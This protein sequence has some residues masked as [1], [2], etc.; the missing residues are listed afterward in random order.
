[1]KSEAPLLERGEV[2]FTIESRIIRELGERLVKQ[3]EIALLELVKNS[4]DA[5]AS[6]CNISYHPPS[7]IAVEDNGHGMTVEDFKSNWMRIGT[8]SKGQAEHSAK[9]GRVITGE[10]GIGRFAV[11]FLGKQLLLTSVAFDDQHGY[12]TRLDAEFDWPE[13]D[14]SEDLGTVKVP[15]TLTR[16]ANGQTGTTLTIKNLQPDAENINFRAVR[17]SAMSVVSPYQTLL[18]PASVTD[19]KR[20]SQN[21]EDVGFSL[22]ISDGKGVDESDVAA[23]VLEHFVLRAVLR[24]DANRLHLQVFRRD[25]EEPRI[26]IAE[27]LENL[28]GPLYADIRFFP[29]RGGTFTGLPVD[30][31]LAK[32]WIKEHSGVKIFDRTFRVYPYGDPGDDWLQLSA[33]TARNYRD[34]RSSV[35]LKHFP[36]DDPTKRSTE[37]NYMLRLPYPE[38]LVGVVQV[39][40]RRDIEQKSGRAG[41]IA[42]A[43]REGF[44]NN[45]AFRQLFDLVRGASEAIAFCDRELQIE[46]EEQEERERLKE[47]RRE[48]RDAVKQIQ[49]NPH[50]ARSVKSSLVRTLTT[51]QRTVEEVTE[52]N[53]ERAATLEVM[54][55]LGV[56]A[57]FMTHEFGVALDNL[58]RAHRTI[59]T[60]AR[61]HPDL[62]KDADAIS[63]RIS[64]LKDFVNYSQAYI[65]GAAQKPTRPYTVKP[66][67][68]QVVRIF[69]RYASARDIEISVDIDSSLL[70]PLVPVSLYNGVALNLYTN[71]LK[72]V[73]A[74]AGTGRREIAFRAWNEGDAHYLEVSDTGIGIPAALKE[75]IFDPLFSTT[76][77]NN[78]DPLGSGMGLGLALVR[79]AAAAYGG[80]VTVVDPPPAFSTAFRVTI[81]IVL[82]E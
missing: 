54:S 28:L 63:D 44:L 25:E 40:G 14:R 27:R 2:T 39:R 37:L 4:Y 5:D 20:D 51:S 76:S 53:K 43:D 82:S 56:V 9:F 49:A 77:N 45:D 57:G 74:K 19:S 71:A 65:H 18:R 33:D 15:Y 70:A 73:T 60:L 69:G 81:P 68:Q 50:I 26:D 38:Q 72:A 61:K 13:F 62:R 22:T 67:I 16:A 7:F 55:L 10:K 78:H 64:N 32:T 12:N 17:T 79:R 24:T 47:L 48:V 34:P 59:V 3:P 30:G 21:P 35:A 11:R 58:E 52:A 42:A 1:M 36:M 41:L 23:V 66:R 31:R 29:H 75:R 80:R 8:S 6:Q 46:Q